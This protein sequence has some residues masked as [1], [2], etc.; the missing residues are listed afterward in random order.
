M[1]AWNVEGVESMG[2]RESEAAASV[3]LRW[4]VLNRTPEPSPLLAGSPILPP[5]LPR[6]P[7]P[8][9]DRWPHAATEYPGILPRFAAFIEHYSWQLQETWGTVRY[10][11]KRQDSPPLN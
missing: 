8:R 3:L 6:V 9:T 11:T 2:Y 5:P 10:P 4:S 7:Y 1:F